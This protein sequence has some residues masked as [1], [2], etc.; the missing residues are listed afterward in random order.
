MG[1]KNP[2]FSKSQAWLDWLSDN[3]PEGV[4][5]TAQPVRSQPTRPHISGARRTTANHV[6]P[7]GRTLGLSPAMFTAR[8]PEAAVGH[9]GRS[10]TI[11][12]SSKA[13]PKSSQPRLHAAKQ[14][15]DGSIAIHIDLPKFQ[16]PPIHVPWKKVFKWGSVVVVVAVIIIGTPSLIRHQTEQQKKKAATTA[17]S[18]PAY[19]PL[20]PEKQVSGAQYDNKRKLYKYNDTYKGLTITVSQQPLPENLRDDP[21]KVKQ[22]AESLGTVESYETTNGIAYIATGQESNTQRVVVVH[23]QLLIFLQ[24]NGTLSPVDWVSYVQNLE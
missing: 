5:H 17:A 22:L 11:K 21:L 24:T 16:L 2:Q 15:D 19:A 13:M 23:R 8:T 14:T 20:K 7:V 18:T 3:S 9:P 12:R 10:Q 1:K 4:S 6:A